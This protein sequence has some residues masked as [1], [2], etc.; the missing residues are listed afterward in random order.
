MAYIVD[1][2][3]LHLVKDDFSEKRILY[4][5]AG[6]KSLLDAA[7]TVA[8]LTSA[9]RYRGFAYNGRYYAVGGHS[10]NLVIDEHY[11]CSRQGIVPPTITPS[12][13]VGAGAT[14]QICYLSYWD[15]L[16][17]ERSSLS[18]GKAVT[19]NTTRAWT[20]LPTTVPGD[21]F[22]FLNTVSCTS[23][24]ISST[25]LSDV[26][27]PGDR[28]GLSNAPTRIARVRSIVAGTSVTLDDTNA[29]LNGAGQTVTIYPKTRPSHL[30][31]WVS[32]AGALPRLAMR[33]RLGTTSVTESTATLALGEAFLSNFER[34]PVCTMNAFYQDRQL[35]AGD[36]RN[37]DTLYLSDLFFPERFGGLTF[38]TRNGDPI[39]AIV[40]QRDYALVFTLESCYMLKGY[41]EDDLE[42]RLIDLEVGA[43]GHLATTVVQGIPIVTNRRGWYAFIG[44]FQHLNG[45]RRT[46]W[47]RYYENNTVGW[48]RGFIVHNPN[49]F[50]YQFWPDNRLMSDDAE[51]FGQALPRYEGWVAD[52]SPRTPTGLMNPLGPRW[53]SD[54]FDLVSSGSD[55]TDMSAAA[56]LRPADSE[57]GTMVFAAI[58]T[59]GAAPYAIYRESFY[60]D[61]AGPGVTQFGNTMADTEDIQGFPGDFIFRSKFYNFGQPGGDKQE[62]K[63]LKRCWFYVVNEHQGIYIRFFAGDEYCREGL[64]PKGG[65]G[66]DP[67]YVKFVDRTNLQQ[68]D[69]ELPH[70]PGESFLTGD[71]RWAPDVVKAIVPEQVTGRGFVFEITSTNFKGDLRIIG[72]GGIFG[73]GKA[74]RNLVVFQEEEL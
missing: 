54:N 49:D 51:L 43:M 44:S 34:F 58:K 59:T 16:T 2:G 41:T 47:Q 24:V 10:D 57:L 31:L 27:R 7:P 9:R 64:Y 5:P 29:A 21:T 67:I 62:G 17:D 26:V 1:D 20:N 70:F 11:R 74:S 30:E 3:T 56:Y 25:T 37:R 14:D 22:R 38:K 39:T 45:G 18:G 65:L 69:S 73:P 61:T 28:I 4:K 19:G 13:A 15:E 33:V 48:S 60:S 72:F 53:G 23:G 63:T 52:Y 50:T 12:V 42:F 6:V 35:M 40:G 68:L 36:E 71:F 32:V 66:Q 8:T 55:W 46:E